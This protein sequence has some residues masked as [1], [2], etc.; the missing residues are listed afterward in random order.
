[1]QPL[2][3]EKR[4]KFFVRYFIEVCAIIVVPVAL[5]GGMFL[6]FINNYLTQE[7]E[8]RNR[9]LLKQTAQ[10]N[11]LIFR[12]FDTVNLLI[13]SDVNIIN[14]LVRMTRG[15]GSF[16]ADDIAAINGLQ[17]TLASIIAS[18][19][20]I[21]SVNI[22]LRGAAAY[23]SS[24]STLTTM[25]AGDRYEWM[26]SVNGGD[27]S[28]MRLHFGDDADGQG[29]YT[30]SVYRKLFKVDG[31]AV[32]N[33]DLRDLREDMAQFLYYAGQEIYI[34]DGS[35]V[36]SLSGNNGSIDRVVA[37]L[38]S[39][40]PG[41]Y[42]IGPK[43]QERLLTVD[44]MERNEWK[45]IVITPFHSLY[46]LQRRLSAIL[47]LVVAGCFIFGVAVAIRVEKRN[48]DRIVRILNAIAMAEEGVELQLGES[49][50]DVYT[51]ILNT[52]IQ[53][54]ILRNYMDAQMTARKYQMETME[55]KALQYQI[56]PH[57]LVN[58][59]KTIYWKDVEI[60]GMDAPVC[61]MMENLLDI[62]GY[63]LADPGTDVTLR[64]EIRHARSFGDILMARH[65]DEVEIRW[66]YGP[67]TEN[68]RCKRLIIQ[69]FIENAFY[70]G[71]RQ[72]SRRPGL[73]D[74]CIVLI[75]GRVR[76]AIEDNG[77]GMPS[78][79]VTAIRESLAMS[80]LPCEHIG[81]FNPHRRIALAYGKDSGVRVESEEGAGT[82]ITIEFPYIDS[83]ST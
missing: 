19:R 42:Q 23:Y 27:V 15:D 59:L 78:A 49:G 44:A 32:V 72:S 14:S 74:I 10:I 17:N 75:D 45:F 76:I 26:R 61:K 20:Y 8:S 66:S 67:E 77:I 2:S 5:M 53:N 28:S 73:V 29:R 58:T 34:S 81:I 60:S 70:H 82:R 40:E 68:A 22:Y 39:K 62:T 69:P 18:N 13:S 11:T 43:G 24:K 35:L 12:A 25:S 79:K 51:Y 16:T 6:Y 63:M 33:I 36:V 37:G 57:F 48:Y 9:Y 50:Q 56:N 55:L 7:I 30:L 1:M 38:A 64:E 31:I 71:I 3:P 65:A 47:A 83:S 46:G 41:S 80:D 4:R 54:N 52:I 21:D